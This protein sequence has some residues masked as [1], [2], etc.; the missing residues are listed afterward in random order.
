M[1]FAQNFCYCLDQMGLSPYA[2]G[3]LPSG[4]FSLF[5]RPVSTYRAQIKKPHLFR[6]GFFLRLQTF[7]TPF[8]GT[9][10]P[11]LEKHSAGTQF[12]ISRELAGLYAGER[13]G[14]S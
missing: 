13:G 7:D 8:C 14:L 10:L 6:C 5:I 2:F 4:I 12:R 11:F 1:A 9:A 3:T